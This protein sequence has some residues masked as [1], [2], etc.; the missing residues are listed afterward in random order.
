MASGDLGTEKREQ[1]TGT[2]RERENEKM[3][4]KLNLNLA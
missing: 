3:G 2:T 1:G 4:T